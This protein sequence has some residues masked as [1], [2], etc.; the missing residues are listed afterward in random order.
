MR[1]YRLHESPPRLGQRHGQRAELS[2]GAAECPCRKIAVLSAYFTSGRAKA[3]ARIFLYVLLSIL[4]F[5]F[6]PPH[7][8]S[9]THRQPDGLQV[10]LPTCHD[11]PPHWTALTRHARA[12]TEID[13][14][15]RCWTLAP[16]RRGEG[17]EVFYLYFKARGPTPGRTRPSWPR[18][19]ILLDLALF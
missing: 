12:E 16:D 14:T 10:Q 6:I 5:Q 2:G 11:R 7:T 9:P 18:S 17:S 8:Y 1:P 3:H 19:I 4:N 13:R 15:H